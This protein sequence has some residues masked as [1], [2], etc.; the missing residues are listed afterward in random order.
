MAFVAFGQRDPRRAL[1]GLLGR[2]CDWLRYKLRPD[3]RPDP[4]LYTLP[5]VRW[6]TPYKSPLPAPIPEPRFS[7]EWG[8]PGL[9][10]WR[11]PTPVDAVPPGDAIGALE[12]WRRR[13][14]ETREQQRQEAASGPGRLVW[15]PQK[16]GA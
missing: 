11:V 4:N 12:E 13:A 7:V 1:L 8:A 9:E 16:G 14:L 5:I 10:R 6:A 2:S 15:H 3:T